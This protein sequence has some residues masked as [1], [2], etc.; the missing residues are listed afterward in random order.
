MNTFDEFYDGFDAS[1][2]VI[3]RASFAASTK[4]LYARLGQKLTKETNT[5]LDQCISRERGRAFDAAPLEGEVIGGDPA[6]KMNASVTAALRRLQKKLR[7]EPEEEK[8]AATDQ[9]PDLRG[10]PYAAAN[11]ALRQLR[12]KIRKEQK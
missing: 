2:A 7:G 12:L 3:L 6:W 11:L 5:W 8:P 1:G 4:R 10:E 9:A